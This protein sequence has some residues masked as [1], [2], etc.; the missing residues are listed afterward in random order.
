VSLTVF[1]VDGACSSSGAIDVPINAC[2]TT[3]PATIA[4]A[5]NAGTLFSPVTFTW[6]AVPGATAYDVYR[7]GSNGLP[8]LIGSVPGGVTSVTAPLPSGTWQWHVAARLASDCDPSLLVSPAVAVTIA[9]VTNCPTATPVLLAPNPG[10]TTFSPITFEWTEVTGAIA[11][12][13][14]AASGGF[15]LEEIG[16]VPAGTTSFVAALPPGPVTWVVETIY[17]SCPPAP[18][19]PSSLVV[20]EEDCSKHEAAALNSP[21]DGTTSPGSEVTFSWNRVDGA[22]G[23]A[24]WVVVAGEP[25]IFGTVVGALTLTT[26]VPVGDHEWFVETLFEG[27]PSTESERRRITIP[28]A[29]SCLSTAPDLIAPAAAAT[30]NSP[31]VTFSWSAVPSALRYELWLSVAAGTPVLMDST[32]AT[33]ITINVPSGEIEWFV[34]ARVNGCDDRDSVRRLF[35]YRPPAACSTAVPMLLLPLDDGRPIA[36][37]ANF[38]WTAVAG[39]TEYRLWLRRGN[40]APELAATTTSPRADGIAVPNGASRWYVEA[41]VGAG[42]PITRSSDGRFLVVPH[43]RSCTELTAPVIAVQGQV[44]AGETFDVLWSAVPGAESYL[45]TEAIGSALSTRTVAGQHFSFNYENTTSSAATYFYRVRAVDNDCSPAAP[46]ELSAALAVTVLPERSTESSTLFGAAAAADHVITLGPEFAGQSFAASPT[47]PWITVTPASGTVPAGGIDLAV[48][49]QISQ[50]PIGSSVAAVVITF[51]STGA[52]RQTVLGSSSVTTPITVNLVTPVTPTPRSTPPPDAL[53]IP[54]VAHAQGVNAQFRSDVRVSNTSSRVIKYQITFVPTGESGMAQ[55]R[56]TTLDIE[57]GGTVALDD[58]LRTWFGT[59]ETSALGMLEIRPLTQASSSTS[60]STVRGL[61]NLVTFASSRTFNLTESGTFGT[62]IAATPYANFI[63]RGSGTSPAPTLSLQ[64]IAQSSLYRTNLGLVEGSGN[65]AEVVVSVF[66]GA[67]SR[68]AAFPL[69]LSGGQHTQLGSFLQQRGIQLDDGRLEIQVASGNGRVSAYAAVV[70]NATGDSLV[71]SPI[72]LGAPGT[73]KYVLPGVA[74]LSAGVPW[75]TD[76]RLFNAG[77]AATTATLTL[78]ALNDS[79]PKTV[80]I[81]LGPGEVRALDRL[82]NTMFGVV[83]DGGAL[84]VTTAAPS[85]LVATARTYRPSSDGGNF[86]QFIPAVTP[87]QAIAVGSRPLQI[88]QVE[89][90]QRF[91]SNIGIAEVSGKPARVQVTVIPPDSKVSGTL[92]VEMAPNQF[93]QINSL[94]SA[95]GLTGTHN[96]RVT[97]RV[98]GGEGRVTAYAATIDAVTHDPTFIPAQ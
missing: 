4:P 43:P 96:A 73:T 3:P 97:V 36:S 77:T 65:P 19:A 37:P 72:T 56:Q 40:S 23:Y 66:N 2:S 90:S 87:E 61:Q 54:A 8:A 6:T 64:Q 88:L 68:V 21:F 75:Q 67:G 52:S 22:D 95:I 62:Y 7:T 57:P 42:C 27:C 30:L 17:E 51:G 45:L 79:E 71:V 70:N 76:V 33:S 48:R 58:I 11:Y 94:L 34:R 14:M 32:T 35:A 20:V 29:S 81:D 12:R 93:R 98:I 50:L 46:G 82:L 16:T 55:G 49:S 74:E 89:E 44:S 85:S 78:H 63:G 13:L 86:G 1:V 24:V 84:H 60:S 39:A 9:E 41:L 31:Q 80:T 10:R 83:N 91:R 92:E 15:P 53:I 38:R 28:R 26:V 59:G 69:T 25:Q 47:R 5:A 18:S